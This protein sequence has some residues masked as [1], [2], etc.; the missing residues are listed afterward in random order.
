MP[1]KDN[2]TRFDSISSIDTL[3]APHSLFSRDFQEPNNTYNVYDGLPL[4][5][6]NNNDSRGGRI[7]H[8]KLCAIL[9]MAL[10]VFNVDDATL[11]EMDIDAEIESLHRPETSP[12]NGP[13]QD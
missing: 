9:D 3:L 13:P 10:D 1:L 2:S 7:N 6:F 12:T 4:V 5:S 11:R 8:Q